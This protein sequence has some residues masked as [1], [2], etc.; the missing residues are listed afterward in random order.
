MPQ[1]GAVAK[2]GSLLDFH[3]NLSSLLI[4]YYCL[5]D[6]NKILNVGRHLAHKCVSCFVRSVRQVQN[7]PN[8]RSGLF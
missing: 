3:L 6:I 4:R 1:N 8:K 2:H 5:Q 7:G